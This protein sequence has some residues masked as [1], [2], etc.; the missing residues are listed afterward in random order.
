MTDTNREQTRPSP[1]EAV[2]PQP[3][4]LPASELPPEPSAAAP[5]KKGCIG[6]WVFWTGLGL[7]LL[8]L[9]AALSGWNGY[10]SGVDLRLS[11]KSTADAQDVINQFNLA[12]QDMDAGRY[13]LSRQRLEWFKIQ[14]Q[15]LKHLDNTIIQELA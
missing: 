5:R 10:R 12:V 15:G 13:G 9:I 4:P 6:S 7:L 2:D 1:V 14:S 3:S 8:A 11:A